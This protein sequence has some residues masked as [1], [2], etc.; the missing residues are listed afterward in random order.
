M[1]LM[2]HCEEHN[3]GYVVGD[4]YP[5]WWVFPTCPYCRKD[6][7]EE[8]KSTWDCPVPYEVMY[9]STLAA[10]R[11]CTTTINTASDEGMSSFPYSDPLIVYR[12]PWWIRLKYF[13]EDV[14]WRVR[15][16]LRILLYGEVD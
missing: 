9:D 12:N 10:M 4:I 5:E 14:L 1:A 11:D 2:V 8:H 3:V 7:L 13:A 16:A 15:A 6:W